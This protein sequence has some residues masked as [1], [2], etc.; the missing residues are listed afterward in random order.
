MEKVKVFPELPVDALALV[1]N[2]A[3]AGI[4]N[5]PH[6]E[7]PTPPALSDPLFDAQETTQSGVGA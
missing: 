1:S 6:E 4:G 3:Q 5:G 2:D 7:A